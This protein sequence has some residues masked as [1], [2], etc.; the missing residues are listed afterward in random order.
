VRG[1]RSRRLLGV[2]LRER[3]DQVNSTEPTFTQIKA[4]VVGAVTATLLGLVVGCTTA[5]EPKFP[6]DASP[7][8]IADL[9]RGPDGH[10]FLREITTYS[11]AD[12]GH[13]A[14]ELFT[15]IPR[16]AT[17][18]HQADA[19]RA[20]ET[21][22]VIASFLADDH[23]M[24]AGAPPNP[25]LLQSFSA[26]LTPYL[27]AAVGDDSGTAGFLP[28]DG[29]G[30]PMRRT[31]AMFAAMAHGLDADREFTGAA[32]DRAATYE[33]SF[34][35]AAAADPVSADAPEPKRALLQAARLRSLVATGAYAA[36]PKATKPTASHAQTQ[37]AY[38]VASL[39]I[40][41]GDPTVDPRYFDAGGRLLSPDAIPD[42]D[43]SLYD[44]QLT[45][46]LAPFPPID[47]A[48]RQFG[49]V[50]QTITRQ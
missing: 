37:V 27:G 50:Y 6:Q 38:E 28:L 31:T 17:S 18:I 4:L 9:V 46:Y 35:K 5:A 10:A 29:L 7:A 25:A 22:H 48:I 43:W 49:G 13:R 24:I 41:A 36:D 30:S 42:Q 14:G 2:V 15:W 11:W 26:S 39:V 16:D 45:A 40:R 8:A 34:A 23:T 12:G 21:A 19:T 32:G 3:R 47:R 1:E 20:G 33:R 44:S